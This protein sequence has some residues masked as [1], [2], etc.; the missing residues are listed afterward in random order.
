MLVGQAVLLPTGQ[1]ASSGSYPPQS[2]RSLISK[3]SSLFLIFSFQ[4]VVSAV[5]CSPAILAIMAYFVQ[6][7]CID[8]SGVSYDDP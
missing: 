1:L 7:C 6:F 8:V 4:D 5:L 2:L 3:P